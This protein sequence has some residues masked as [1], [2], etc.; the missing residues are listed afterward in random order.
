MMRVEEFDLTLDIKE[1]LIIIDETLDIE[2][3]CEQ[4]PLDIEDSC[5]QDP[6]DIEGSCEQDSRQSMDDNVNTDPKHNEHDTVST[7][8]IDLLDHIQSYKGKQ[9]KCDMCEFNSSYQ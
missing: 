6:L 5:E 8:V 2:D 7:D 3:S 9:Y 4:D 1:N